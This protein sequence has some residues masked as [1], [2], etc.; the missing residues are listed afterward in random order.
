MGY[1]WL[2]GKV[3]AVLELALWTMMLASVGVRGRDGE[4]RG[5][6]RRRD[7]TGTEG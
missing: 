7:E 2:P 6:A 1:G 5:G 4:E 3:A